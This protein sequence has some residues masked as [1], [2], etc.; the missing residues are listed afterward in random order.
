MVKLY[1]KVEL[2]QELKTPSG[3]SILQG[4]RGT[5][6]KVYPD[7]TYTVEIKIHNSMMLRSYEFV[8]LTLPQEK[9]KVV[10]LKSNCLKS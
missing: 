7:N 10:E 3:R 1:D 4:T 6:W 5:V 2:L 9:F 8:T